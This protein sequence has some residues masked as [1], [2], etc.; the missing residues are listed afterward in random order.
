M[1]LSAKHEISVHKGISLHHEPAPRCVMY[2]VCMKVEPH[3]TQQEHEAKLSLE[4]PLAWR[5]HADKFAL[6][7]GDLQPIPRN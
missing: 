3:H 6:Q 1:P 2:E 4:T 5:L 7:F